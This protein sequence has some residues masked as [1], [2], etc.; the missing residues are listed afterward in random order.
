MRC[1]LTKRS[2]E[3]AMLVLLIVMS[4][5]QASELRE[6][7]GRVVDDTGQPVVPALAPI[8]EFS[9]QRLDLLER[10]S[11]VTFRMS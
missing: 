6:V 9:D 4:A 2:I 7:R 8:Q 11:G 3:T 1:T 5:S 10:R